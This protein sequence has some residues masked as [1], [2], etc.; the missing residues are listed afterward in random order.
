MFSPAILKE[1][2]VQLDASRQVMKKTAI[3]IFKEMKKMAGDDQFNEM[4]VN[5]LPDESDQNRV[6]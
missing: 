5:A 4:L 1:M 6:K 2:R 3:L